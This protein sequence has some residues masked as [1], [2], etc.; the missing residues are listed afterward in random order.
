MLISMHALHKYSIS[1]FSSIALILTYYLV[2]ITDVFLCSVVCVNLTQ[3]F[4]YRIFL[5]HIGTLYVKI[6]TTSKIFYANFHITH[7]FS[8]N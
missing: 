1:T 7:K 4:Q 2:L 5:F 6:I 8:A 3:Y